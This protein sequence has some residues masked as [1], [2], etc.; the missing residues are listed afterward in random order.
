MKVKDLEARL[1]MSRANIRFYEKEGLLHPSRRANGYRNYTEED[2]LTLEKIALLRRLEMPIEVIRQVQEGTLPL[3]A[4]L[5]QQQQALSAMQQEMEQAKRI[6]GNM[7]EDQ[8]TYKALEPEKYRNALPPARPRPMQP[9]PTVAKEP[10]LPHWIRRLLA[11]TMDFWLCERLWFFTSFGIFKYRD[12]SIFLSFAITVGMVLLLEPL[13]LAT[14]GTTPGKWF[15][16]LHLSLSEDGRER[17]SY[18]MALWRTLSVLLWHLLLCIP[19]VNI[20]T[21]YRILHSCKHGEEQLWNEDYYYH[22][23]QRDRQWL[24]DGAAIVLIT[25]VI[26][27]GTQVTA[28]PFQAPVT[29]EEYIRNINHSMAL[30]AKEGRMASDGSWQGCDD[31]AR[32]QIQT[33]AQ[34]YVNQVEVYLPKQ[35]TENDETEYDPASISDI[36]RKS[37]EGRYFMSECK[38]MLVEILTAL[39]GKRSEDEDVNLWMS[40]QEVNP[41]GYAQLL[42]V[43]FEEWE[44]CMKE[45][46]G[47]DSGGYGPY[48][49]RVRRTSE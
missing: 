32:H 34:G 36:V 19:I 46:S 4:A 42:K 43:T 18:G 30:N 15:F 3:S 2:A 39:E 38:Q 48:L 25:L 29:Q 20:I 7:L 40:N 37:A 5:Y 8:V 44:V 33:D 45:L 17:L 11:R 23:L 26:L 27:I 6:C 10:A 35:D 14:W 31:R 12:A 24:Y 49:L 1:D 41:Y 13:L 16:G 22:S 21:V 47:E 9:L 28:M